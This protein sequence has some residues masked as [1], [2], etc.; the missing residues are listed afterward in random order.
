MFDILELFDSEFN[1]YLAI[2]S[3]ISILILFYIFRHIFK[4]S[5]NL[6]VL[7]LSTIVYIFMAGTGIAVY[8][9]SKNEYMYSTVEKYHLYGKIISINEDYLEI[10]V[11]KSTLE[12]V[13]RG[14][15]NVKLTGNTVY[16]I[17]T[18]S[19]DTKVEREKINSNANVEIICK[20]SGTN[21]EEVTALKV[22]KIIY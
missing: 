5:S 9:M 2:I 3:V 18:N 4:H 15:F 21:D 6:R 13:G 17:Y 14:K 7:F 20:I 16:S 11:T 8:Y 22:T 19:E 12:S 1:T 10:N